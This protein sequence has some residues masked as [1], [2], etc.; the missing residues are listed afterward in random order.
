VGGFPGVAVAA[1]AV[2]V[3]V[4]PILGVLAAAPQLS[5]GVERARGGRGNMSLYS[6]AYEAGHPADESSMRAWSSSSK[7]HSPTRHTLI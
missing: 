7:A 6:W 2:L 5:A 4:H 3:W 1:A